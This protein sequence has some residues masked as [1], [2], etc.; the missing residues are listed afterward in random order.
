MVNSKAQLII[1][2]A[3]IKRS[4][5]SMNIL[6]IEPYYTGSHKQWADGLI[7]HS[8]HDIDLLTLPGVFWKWRMHGAAVTLA[9]Q[10]LEHDKSYDLI[11][12]TDML[13]LTTFVA[14][15]RHQTYDTPF[16]LYFHENQIT[17]PWSETDRDIKNK[18]DQHYG[19]INY[20]S[21]LAADQVVFNSMYHKTSFIQSLPNFLKQFPDHNNLESIQ[22][23]EQKSRVLPLG[24]ELNTFQ[25]IAPAIPTPNRAVLLWNHRWEHDKN[26]EEFFHA[27]YQLKDRGIEYKLIVLGE[28]FATRP[29]IFDQAKNH[30]KEEILH[31][32][33]A[34]NYEEYI[35]WLKV[36]DILPVTSN[37]DFFGVSV[38][39]A[40]YHNV[41][42]LLPSRLV[43]PEHIPDELQST[44][45]YTSH[46]LVKRLQGMIMHVSVLRKQN[47]RQFVEHYDWEFM[48]TSYD[49]FFSNLKAL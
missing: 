40:M 46:E 27:L 34:S 35:A 15:T 3:W 17:Y 2:A 7:K 13:D 49:T 19:F 30:L 11:V 42:P 43:Y 9:Q 12:A 4:G 21:A 10:F 45:F 20:S 24:L 6:L 44:F 47:T 33:F 8:S 41:I 5:F 29:T 23:I 37:H 18:R 26:P 14:L 1:R 36:A 25:K 48:K 16:M 28:S 39:E 22:D 32:G 31:F 38:V